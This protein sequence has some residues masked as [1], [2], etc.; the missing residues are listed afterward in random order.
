[1]ACEIVVPG[2]IRFIWVNL[3]GKSQR[4][5]GQGTLIQHYG[6]P[7][8]WEEA[9]PEDQGPWC[10]TWW[11]LTLA[12]VPHFAHLIITTPLYVVWP[13]TSQQMT[14]IFHQ[15][16][17]Q[18][19]KAKVASSSSLRTITINC[20]FEDEGQRTR[21]YRKRLRGY[22]GTTVEP[23]PWQLLGGDEMEG[24][25]G[26][27]LEWTSVDGRVWEMVR[28]GSDMNVGSYAFGWEQKQ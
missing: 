20:A 24:T 5:Q 23:E 4:K 17:A 21:E 18:L 12:E 14:K 22:A 10:S 28:P 8:V 26:A 19:R 16:T 11:R 9:F 15:W 1:M 25:V 7:D 2:A 3:T 13:P 27:R 6:Y